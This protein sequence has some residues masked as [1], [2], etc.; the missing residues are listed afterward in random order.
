MIE[1]LLDGTAR[2]PGLH[3]MAH[4]IDVERA[5]ADIEAMGVRTWQEITPAGG[6]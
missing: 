1:Q 2:R 6:S 5:L 3:R 4:L